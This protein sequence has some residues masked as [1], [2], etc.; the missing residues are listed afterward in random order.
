MA[1][2]VVA[3]GPAA[4]TLYEIEAA[5]LAFAEAVDATEDP[6]RRGRALVEI[7]EALRVARDKRDAVVGFLRYCEN[8]QKFADEE[9]DRIQRRKERIARIHKE[10]AA[11]VVG[12]IKQF[13]APDKR[14][15]QRLEGNHSTMRIQKNPDSVVVR[16]EQALP[17]VFKDVTVTLPAC[18]WEA[19]LMSVRPEDRPALEALVKRTEIK[20]DRKALAKEL[21]AG[22]DIPGAVL[23]PGE[24]RLAIR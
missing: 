3:A 8:Q 20:P 18:V 5:L 16:D 21:Q 24:F 13:A 14:G 19:L 7:G 9:I 17:A 11:Y 6:Q 23:E 1:A 10:L 22:A 2:E 15:M 4:V 12:M